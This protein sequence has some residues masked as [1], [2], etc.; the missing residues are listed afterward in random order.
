[1]SF[2]VNDVRAEAEEIL[3]SEGVSAVVSEYDAVR[4][5][6]ACMTAMGSR[7]WR[8]ASQYFMDSTVDRWYTLPTS[9]IRS[10]M[11]RDTIGIPTGLA[12]TPT[13]TPGAA[14][15]GYQITAVNENGET[16]ACT[17]V[18]TT[19]GNA[20]LSAVN[21]NALAWTA[22]TG[23]TTYNVYRIT[24][25]TSP[26]T[27]GLISS[28]T[29]NSLNDTGLAGDGAAGPVEDFSGDEYSSYTIRDRRIKFDTADDYFLMYTAYPT[30]FDDIA[31]TVDLPDIYLYPIAKYMAA[32]KAGKKKQELMVEFYGQMNDLLSEVE[33]DNEPF[34]VKEVW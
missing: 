15:W 6:N 31:D 30:K 23:A 17:E 32:A 5:A 13:G 3:R 19:T 29:T 28:P 4:L 14:T 9:F 2:T 22:V 21:Y 24:C 16:L 33:D 10:I 34:Q 18:K 7:G 11:V 27:T 8:D 25:A 26:A 1:M 12:I 20:T